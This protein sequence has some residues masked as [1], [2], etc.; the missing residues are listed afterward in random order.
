MKNDK[1]NLLKFIKSTKGK[2][3]ALALSVALL[4]GITCGCEQ[5]NNSKIKDNGFKPNH[6]ASASID[7][8][9][10]EKPV[11]TEMATPEVSYST[12]EL[13]NKDVLV[14]ITSE[15]ELRALTGW[16]LSES[17]KSLTKSFSE[18]VNMPV[19][20]TNVDGLTATVQVVVSNLD[21]SFNVSEPKYSTTKTTNDIV[22][23]TITSDEEMQAVKGWTLLMD[24]KSILKVYG[25]NASETVVLKD[26]VGNTV[27]KQVEVANIDNVFNPVK[28]N[29]STTELTNKDVVVTITSDEEM[30]AV[31]GWTLSYNKK[32]LFKT[33]DQNANE[34]LIVKDLAGNTQ[35]VS[36]NVTNIDKTFNMP[37]VSYSTEKLTNGNVV[38][39]IT[40]DEEMQEVEGWTLSTD[41][42]SMK[43][44]YAENKLD[45]VT[46]RDKVG[47][48]Q[49]VLVIVANIDNKF[50]K[51]TVKYENLS[52]GNVKVTISSNE[53]M[54]AVNGWILSN[55]EKSL[56][57]EYTS[58]KKET[59]TV[60]DLAGNTQEVEIKVTGIQN[61]DYSSSNNNNNDNNKPGGNE[62]GGNE[63]GGNEPGGNE[64]GGNEPG[65]NEP[66]GNE[67]GG[68]EPGGNEPGGNEPGGNEPGG[69]EPGGNEPGGNDDEDDRDNENSDKNDN[70]SI[71]GGDQIEDDDIQLNITVPN[72]D[73]I[74]VLNQLRQ[75]KTVLETV[76][77]DGLEFEYPVKEEVVSEDVY[78]LGLRK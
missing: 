28:I 60:K 43:R 2:F 64:P 37:Q 44:T 16:T 13:T 40:A 70:E 26:K 61:Y 63:P 33:F 45:T 59:L 5:A 75:M 51:V 39:T 3:C 36:V 68:N 32:S 77:V 6:S 15:D 27:T 58:N 20:V 31:E 71:G 49:K 8:V 30:Q 48:I 57:K 76:K 65:G 46:V 11:V 55:D 12:K 4:G 29:Y 24:K 10:P 74:V 21:K 67:P 41:K 56:S 23:V 66:G 17:K 62:P 54:Q 42:K 25:K 35:K 53:K 72:E 14:T 7:P 9:E 78:V 34:T 47:N 52:N 50:N 19:T 18:N 73:K 38:V 1:N 22:I 69:N